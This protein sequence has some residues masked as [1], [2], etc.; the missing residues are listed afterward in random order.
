MTD[1]WS[2]YWARERSGA[3]LP[4]APPSVQARL[5]QLWQVT[6][7]AA[8]VAARWLDVAAGGGAV[9]R[10][11]RAVRPDVV[12]TGIDA[13]AVPPEAAALGVQGG[14]D[15]AALPFGDGRFAVVSSQ[16]G[17]EYCPAAAWAEAARVLAPGGALRLICHHA[18]SR[19]VAQNAARLAAMR[20][21]VAAGVFAL[22]ESVAAGRGEEAGLVA[23]VVAARAAHAGQSVAAELPQALGQWA[24]AGR[25]DAVA[26]IR[27][28]AEAEMARLAAMQAAALDDAAIA[29]RQTWLPGLVPQVDVVADADGVPICWSLRA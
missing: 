27:A 25:A 12:V 28:E 7:R 16:F 15:A 22:A 29:V 24:R 2:R 17:L 6:A 1:A 23:A 8:P 26:A 10:I 9:A 18:G 14:I 11:V 21:L 5:E 4:G 3:C 19:A 13:A 20:A